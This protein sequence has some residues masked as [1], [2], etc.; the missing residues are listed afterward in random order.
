M[1]NAFLE[2]IKAR[3]SI[4]ALGPTLP[5]S[6]DQVTHIIMLVPNVDNSIDTAR[7]VTTPP[8]MLPH[9]IV[10]NGLI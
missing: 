6:E 4:Y 5:L 9:D 2:A 8:I 3:R 7:T 10:L 1:S